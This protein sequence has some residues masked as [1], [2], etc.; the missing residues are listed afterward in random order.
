MSDTS[1]DRR[2]APIIKP[3]L[4]PIDADLVN[5]QDAAIR[6]MHEAI[7]ARNTMRIADEDPAEQIKHD[8]DNVSQLVAS[9]VEEALMPLA[10]ARRTPEDL[11]SAMKE[12]FEPLETYA[13][14]EAN[15]LI[16]KCSGA[17]AEQQKSRQQVKQSDRKLAMLFLASALGVDR[18]WMAVYKEID[19]RLSTRGLAA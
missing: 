8:V 10:S 1:N 7:A 14:S 15:L 11:V 2:P 5:A 6:R 9:A 18:Q 19:Q 12:F 4:L 3:G 13:R 17:D 16:A